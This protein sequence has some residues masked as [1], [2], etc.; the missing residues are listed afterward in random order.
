MGTVYT[1]HSIALNKTVCVKVLF[2]D[3]AREGRNVDF[4][5]REARS[6]SKLD[7]PNIVHVYGFGQENGL[8]Y[9]TMSYIEGPSLAEVIE[10]KGPMNADIA[11]GIM[12]KVFEALKH[13]HSNSIIHRDI[14]PSNILLGPGGH[15]FIVDFGLARAIS[16]E[17]SLTQAGEMVGTD[18]FMSPEQGLAG[19]IDQRADLYSAGATYFYLLTGK[20]PFEGKSYLEVVN[21]HIGEPFP[22]IIVLKPDVPL[23]VSR[24]LDQLTRKQPKDRY[25]SAALVIEDIQRLSA[26]E[27]KG[28]A[29]SDE[30]SI[31]IPELT[32]RL[33]GLPAAPQSSATPRTPPQPDFSPFRLADVPYEEAP[34][35]EF[36]DR[37]SSGEK[38]PGNA[39]QRQ[40]AELSGAVKMVM[41]C[42]VSFTAMS[43]FLLAGSAGT[44][45]PEIWPS[46][47]TPFA[48]N[49]VG[50]GFFWGAGLVLTV[51][52][53]LLKPFKFALTRFSF[54]VFSGLAAYAGAIYLPS[55]D[56]QSMAAK[57]LFCL[58]AAVENMFSRAALPLY[59][60]SLFIAASKFILK[61]YRAA[62][63]ATV[64]AYCLSL[65]LT[66]I[67]FSSGDTV[68]H[69]AIGYLALA[70]TVT[71]AGTAAALTKKSFVP[72]FT[73][74]FLFL[75]ANILLFAMFTTPHTGA[76][77]ETGSYREPQRG[78]SMQAQGYA[79]VEFDPDGRPAYKTQPRAGR[80][81]AVSLKHYNALASG[82]KNDLFNTAGLVLIALF[83]LLMAGLHFAEEVLAPRSMIEV[84]AGNLSERRQ[85]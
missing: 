49:P 66:Y 22:S 33:A 37:V 16:E 11:S 43:C 73:T 12:L 59:S 61:P 50:A 4:F 62:K 78:R 68:I 84:T 27:K 30:R 34:D 51:W 47:L 41:Y 56:T 79:V 15:P 14:K 19:E 54:L 25:Q 85:Q 71:L 13:A 48:A 32:A 57:A 3:L 82:L 80:N 83:L 44:P 72:V 29:F 5:L 70:G 24:V 28:E 23:W 55:P 53:V 9:I 67:Y 39:G 6:A 77:P 36:C 1:A 35:P 26:A 2:P 18:Y 31:E 69:P 42:A 76:A 81:R 60:I 75:A 21:K 65:L 7:H 64:G 52:S 46:M 74:P 38:S 8:H 17:K 40:Q 45:K 10:A 20:Y 58:K 63:G